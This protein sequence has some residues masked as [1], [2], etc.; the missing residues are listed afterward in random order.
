[1]CGSIPR[2][3]TS[4]FGSDPLRACRFSIIC[5][6]QL[7]GAKADAEIAGNDLV[8][9]ARDPKLLPRTLS[10]KRHM[11]LGIKVIRVECPHMR[12]QCLGEPA[13]FDLS[14]G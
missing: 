14:F 9:H 1:M 8:T 2:S 5:A 10:I 12:Q 11:L 7:D 3:W 6:M 4:Q 13:A